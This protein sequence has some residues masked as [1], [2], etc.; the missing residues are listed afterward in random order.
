[1]GKITFVKDE[2]KSIPDNSLDLVVAFDV[3]E[4]MPADDIQEF[5]ALVGKALKP[6]TGQFAYHN[7]WKQQ[8]LYPMHFDYEKQWLGWLDKA[9]LREVSPIKAVHKES[10]KTPAKEKA[11]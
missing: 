10:I 9:G 1:M 8:D 3:L 11:N 4:H 6:G 5:L 2:W 7:N